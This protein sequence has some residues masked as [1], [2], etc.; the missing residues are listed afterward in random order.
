MKPWFMVFLIS[1]SLI[2]VISNVHSLV[3]FL[4]TTSSRLLIFFISV[5]SVLFNENSDPSSLH[6]CGHLSSRTAWS[7]LRVLCTQ[8]SSDLPSNPLCST[9]YCKKVNSIF[10]KSAH[11][12][13]QW[14]SITSVSFHT[15]VDTTQVLKFCSS[16]GFDQFIFILWG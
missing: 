8:S 14:V 16:L 6:P 1:Q 9:H 2:W 13:F 4:W 11:S 10:L 5:A 3:L 12:I 15:D 7:V